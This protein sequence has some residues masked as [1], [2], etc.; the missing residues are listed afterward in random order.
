MNL[1]LTRPRR[2][3]PIGAVEDHGARDGGTTIRIL[4]CCDSGY[5]Q[6]LA[7]ALVSLLE[8]N[9]R[10]HLDIHL[11]TGRRDADAEA[12]LE[13]SIRPFTNSTLQIHAFSWPGKDS[14]FTSGYITGDTY[15]RIF[16]PEVLDASI[17]RILYLDADLLVVADLEDLWT[18]DLGDCALAAVSDPYA[19]GRRAQLGIPEGGGYVN[20][21]VLLLDL[22]RWRAR[23]HSARLAAYIEQEG[24]RLQFH[25]QDALNA[26]LHAEIKVVDYRWNF[27]ARMFSRAD[28]KRLAD[29]PVVVEAIRAAA[30]RPAVIHYTTDRKPWRFVVATPKKALYHRYRCRTAWRTAIPDDRRWSRLAERLYNH[31]MFYTGS[32]ATWD[33][34]LR[35]TNLGRVVF[36]ACRLAT[37][38]FHGAWR[39]SPSR[40]AH[41]SRLARQ[42]RRV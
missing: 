1:P 41:G 4:F 39:T 22:A 40:P 31:L 23:G 17:E 15:T 21:G 14:W 24:A 36:H 11:I 19:F 42:D 29:R 20:A 30:R 5:Y 18:T 38:L 2:D 7:A 3:R 13:A 25:D 35:A 6:H 12:R 16:A 10:H 26:L 27:Q 34:F 9:R 28:L 32:T 33:W 37:W 8:S